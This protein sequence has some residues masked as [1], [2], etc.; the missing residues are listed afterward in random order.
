MDLDMPAPA[1][2][3]RQLDELRDLFSAQSAAFR[4]QPNPPASERRAHLG[5]LCRLLTDNIDDMAAAIDADFGHRSLH[6]TKL[7]EVFPSLMAAKHARSHV[8]QWMRPEGKPVSLWFWAGRAEVVKQPLGVVGVLAPWNYP[9]YLS[10]GPL[11]SALAAG[12]RVILKPSEFTPHFSELLARLIARYFPRDRVAVVTGGIET[13]QA[14]SSLPFDHLL[15]TG[16]TAVGREVMRA[17][18]E[19]LTPVT[20]E[21]GGKSPAIIAPGFP[22]E[23]AVRRIL[24]GKCLN[25]GQTCIAPDYALIPEGTEADFIAAA[26]EAVGRLYPGGAASPDFTSII[27]ARHY[28]RLRECVNDAANKGAQVIELA[29]GASESAR[30]F[31]PTLILGVGEGM[32][33]MQEEIM[34]PVLP[35][36][37]YR[38]VEEALG[39]VTDHPRP[40][41]LYCFDNDP[42]RVRR[43][44]AESLS[45]GV[46]I[47]DTIFHI[48][49]DALPFGGV[50][51]SGMGHYHGEE[52]F[53]TFSKRKGV[54]LQSRLSFVG[55]LRP[56]YGRVVERVLRFVLR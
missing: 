12:N 3:A 23:T 25:A 44:L 24:A 38:T 36:K 47:N 51:S 6:E 32:R 48:A 34:G 27:S 5:T 2:P 56:P 20:L 31:A 26:R 53:N 54:F 1:D 15:F 30:K 14:F 18:A 46:T 40:L 10:A 22:I 29:G 41:A 21:L 33:I 39:Y 43:I 52:G 55:L 11:A 45:G 19:N 28:A 4:R 13:A 42:A 37:T 8:A 17:A 16:S 35:V 49:Q 9:L 50:G 7:L